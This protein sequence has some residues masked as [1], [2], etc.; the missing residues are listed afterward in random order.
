MV[1]ENFHTRDV[2]AVVTFDKEE[3]HAAFERIDNF[4]L[5]LSLRTEF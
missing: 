2:L 5:Y 1:T 4:G 3:I